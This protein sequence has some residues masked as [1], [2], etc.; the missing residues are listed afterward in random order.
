MARHTALYAGSFDPITFGHLDVLSRARALFDDISVGLG[1]NPDKQ[2][3]FSF[4][5]RCDMVESLVAEMVE[6][7]PSGAPIRVERYTGLTVDYARQVG[8]VA[9]IRG[10]RNITDLASECQIAMTNRQVADI[11]TVFIITGEKYAF[12]SSSLI[13]QIAAMGGSI[14]R[15]ASFVPPVVLEGMRRKLADPSNP[16]GRLAADQI[17]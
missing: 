11:E 17:D 2:A 9:I 5:E 4:D 14:D 3:L 15:L 7:D 12:T 13:R 6:N 8:A 16:L 10:I 1:H